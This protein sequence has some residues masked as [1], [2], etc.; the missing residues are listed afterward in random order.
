MQGKTV[1]Y[2]CICSVCAQTEFVSLFTNIYLYALSPSLPSQMRSR[3]GGGNKRDGVGPTE[4]SFKFNFRPDEPS[5]SDAENEKF[6]QLFTPLSQQ[7]AAAFKTEGS[8]NKRDGK[9]QE[10][11]TSILSSV[12]KSTVETFTDN[13]A[14]YHASF[15][16]HRQS[17]RM[18]YE[19]APVYKENPITFLQCRQLIIGFI[20]PNSRRFLP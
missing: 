3:R 4:S 8:T 6:R 1:F 14:I 7:I 15:V 9:I 11:F 13:M 2:I 18:D 20:H 19:S 10:I 5:P 16:G 12:R 17:G